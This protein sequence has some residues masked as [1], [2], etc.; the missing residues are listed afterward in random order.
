[1]FLAEP[2]KPSAR[3]P[4]SGIEW[5]RPPLL[6][7]RYLS[8]LPLATECCMCTA[9]ILNRFKSASR[10]MN[11]NCVFA[12]NYK[13]RTRPGYGE[14]VNGFVLVNLRDRS[15]AARFAVVLRDAVDEVE[16]A[17]FNEPYAV[18]I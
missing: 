15:N 1:M 14:V 12:G 5:V 11:P 7:A 10:I 6:I 4:S 16:F 9:S 8:G 17:C 2:S 18:H 13:V 3:L